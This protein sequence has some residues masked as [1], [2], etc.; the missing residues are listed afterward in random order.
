MSIIQSFL[1]R[2]K[3]SNLFNL[4]KSLRK[5][6]LQVTAPPPI[7]PRPPPPFSFLQ[8]PPAFLQCRTQLSF[9][10]NFPRKWV[11]AWGR[12]CGSKSLGCVAFV[13]SLEMSSLGRGLKR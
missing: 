11:A 3:T 4:S 10:L 5:Q 1:L 2:F 9:H 6:Y 7:P 13:L 12:F 8:L